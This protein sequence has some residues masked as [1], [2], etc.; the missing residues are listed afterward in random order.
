MLGAVSGLALTACSGLSGGTGTAT[1][2]AT[3][4]TA[5]GV[6]DSVAVNAF[7]V[8]ETG[9]LASVHYVSSTRISRYVD[10]AAAQLKAGDCLSVRSNSPA[11]AATVS[12]DRIQVLTPGSGGCRY[13][14]HS[15]TA[16]RPFGPFAAFGT[17]TAVAPQSL[18]LSE[19]V[20]GASPS[21]RTARVTTTS[22]TQIIALQP[23][24][25]SAI[26]KG[27]C[28]RAAGTEAR[29]LFTAKTIDLAAAVNGGC[30]S[31]PVG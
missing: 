5:I 1:S 25:G 30:A 21:T 20:P 7:K 2:T 15:A 13:A 29:G 23:A 8:Q 28:V 22:A 12:A 6:I 27:E 4:R 10:I 14:G 3:K 17:V 11:G 18:T 9:E 24:A 26:A 16:A 31:S 19:E